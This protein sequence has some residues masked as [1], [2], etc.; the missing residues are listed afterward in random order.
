ERVASNF[1][2]N[3]DEDYKQIV[4][5]IMHQTDSYPFKSVPIILN[6]KLG[7]N[8]VNKFIVFIRRLI[9]LR[10]LV[11]NSKP[12]CIISFGERCNFITMLSGVNCKKILTVHS[13]IS[14][15]NKKKGIYG[16]VSDLV[17]RITY[18][19]AEKVVA[20]SEV[21]K[22]DLEKKYK[23]K[24]VTRIYNGHD[25]RFIQEKSN[26]EISDH[27][28]EFTEFIT[29]GRITYAKGHWHLIK[30]ISL[31]KKYK[32]NVKL[33]IIGAE[34]EKIFDSLEMLVKKL[35]LTENII[36]HGHDNEP[37]KYVSKSKVFVLSSIFEGFPG[38]VI[39]S[40][41]CGIPI[42]SSNSGGATEVILDGCLPQE[43]ENTRNYYSEYGAITPSL[44]QDF[45]TSNYIPQ[46]V[47]HLARAMMF[48]LENTYPRKVLLARAMDYSNENMIECYRNEIEKL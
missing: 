28:N 20:V 35:D 19:N 21:V 12:A 17:A 29:V 15:E 18:N 36:F 14:I 7:S 13:Q 9:F 22:Q 46:E 8:L 42:V 41:A 32:P 10:R 40:L 25:I 4:Y 27:D 5:S 6:V 34:E 43:L 38:V 45:D 2:M 31:I 37:F 48:A 33:R 30:A 47:E 26:E 44:P 1:S 3:L 16:L 11:K 23:L 24:N 39:E